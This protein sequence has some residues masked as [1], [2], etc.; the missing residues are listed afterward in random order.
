MYQPVDPYFG[1]VVI[2]PTAMLQRPKGR[3]Q[4]F[5]V[6]SDSTG[7]G[8]AVAQGGASVIEAWPVWCAEHLGLDLFNLSIGG[9]GYIATPTAISRIADVVAA[10]LDH[11]VIAFGQNDKAGSTPAEITTAAQSL[12]DAVKAQSP[13][14]RI[15]L[16]GIHMTSQALD[17]KNE[18]LETALRALAA[19][20]NIPFISQRDPQNLLATATAWAATN[21]YIAGEAV[22]QDGLVWICIS[23]HTSGGSFDATKFRATS[24]LT[25]T[26]RVGTTA[27]NG[28]AD[29]YVTSEAVHWTLAG[30]RAQGLWFAE[31]LLPVMADRL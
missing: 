12:I 5:G 28:N 29:L 22:K 8:A 9:S 25:G 14:T 2:P 21:S 16:G 18:P 30:H 4:K 7:R 26:G 27:G 23:D 31:Q 10:D 11:L 15:Y 19:A 20:N 3:R 17:V 1:G 13:R 24:L 6:I